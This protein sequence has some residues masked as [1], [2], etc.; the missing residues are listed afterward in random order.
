MKVRDRL[1][2][3]VSVGYHELAP[4][5][6]SISVK[7]IVTPGQCHLPSGLKTW[8]WSAQVY[9]TRSRSSWGIGDLADLRRLGEWA[10]SI[11]AGMVLI[12]P[13][14]AALPVLP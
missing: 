9:A 13:L 7:L 8:G 11:G 12:N 1:P 10:K 6:R 14:N 5:G 4:M 3:S 2:N